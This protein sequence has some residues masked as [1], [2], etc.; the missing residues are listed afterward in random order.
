MVN[1]GYRRGAQVWRCV[2]DGAKQK[3]EAFPVF[4]PKALAGIGELPDT[5]AD[6]CLPIRLERQAPG[7]RVERFRLR[8]VA[9][10]VERLRERIAGFVERVHDHLDGARPDLPEGLDDRGQDAVEP[11]LAIADVAGGEWSQ[12]ARRAVVALRAE[13]Q[14]EDES[15]GVRL[16][17]DV[18]TILEE[19]GVDRIS[20][21][22][23][24]DALHRLD[25][26][27]WSEWYGKPL[28]SRG[29]SKLL[30]PYAIRS[31]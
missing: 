10:E 26:A 20:T 13:R 4:C 1:A 30:K 9:P 28:T 22:G 7:E 11:L 2:G 6:R 18:R 8:D 15:S 21:E 17:A 12:R 24:L 5:V 16:L 29:L 23:L 3:V 14:V 25:E 19:R 27:P 31:R